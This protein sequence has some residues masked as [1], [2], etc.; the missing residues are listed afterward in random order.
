VVGGGGEKDHRPLLRP[1]VNGG[2]TFLVLSSL[3]LG[4]FSNLPAEAKK[5]LIRVPSCDGFRKGVLTG[6]P[7]LKIAFGEIGKEGGTNEAKKG[8][9]RE[10]G[11]AHPLV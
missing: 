4:L 8:N 1:G 9:E 2:K 10:S 3:H 6:S 11:R 5:T 7:S